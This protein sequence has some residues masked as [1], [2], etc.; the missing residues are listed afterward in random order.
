MHPKAVRFRVIF[1]AI[2]K[3]LTPTDRLA[4]HTRTHPIESSPHTR[5]HRTVCTVGAELSAVDVCRIVA[6]EI[7]RGDRSHA[8]DRLGGMNTENEVRA[9]L[10]VIVS[11]LLSAPDLAPG[12]R[13]ELQS[14]DVLRDDPL[15][16]LEK[17]ERVVGI[18]L[19][20][21]YSSV[22][23]IAY[24]KRPSFH[25]TANLLVIQY[26]AGHLGQW[27]VRNEQL[28]DAKVARKLMKAIDTQ[29]AKRPDSLLIGAE[30]FMRMGNYEQAA[31]MLLTADRIKRTAA[32]L[33][34]AALCLF[35]ARDYRGGLWA[36]RACLI[37]DL[38]EFDDPAVLLRVQMAESSLA[39]L[40]TPSTRWGQSGPPEL[41]QGVLTTLDRLYKAAFIRGRTSHI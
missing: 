18:Q 32:G 12:A 34:R 15:T 24:D 13:T 1:V 28:E 37:E 16:V 40:G 27:A 39:L 35:K 36:T 25:R 4:R 38:S 7:W 20:A 5:G 11:A 30:E 29:G 23:A 2:V 3:I 6:A 19:P 9:R 21:R 17:S 31:G 26:I 33:Y 10:V 22:H 41:P 8:F 14:I